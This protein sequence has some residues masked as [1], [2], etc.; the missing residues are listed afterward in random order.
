MKL[1]AV[2]DIKRKKCNSIIVSDSHVALLSLKNCK[3]KCNIYK[4]MIN[5]INELLNFLVSKGLHLISLWFPSHVGILGNEIADVLAEE[6]REKDEVDN[7]FGLSLD[8]ISNNLKN[9][10]N[11]RYYENVRMNV[12]GSS[13]I[14]YY[15][16]VT[17]NIPSV[18]KPIGVSKIVEL[19]YKRLRLGYRYPSIYRRECEPY[20]IECRP[21][22]EPKR[23]TLHQYTVKC[24]KSDKFRITNCNLVTQVRLC[25]KSMH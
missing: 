10:I 23:N 4:K 11:R 22:S 17:K 18:G 16:E 25:F 8:Q 21:C 7:D 5:R 24:N 9:I 20:Y 15:L 12:N 2:R 3:V 6:A 19:C 13:S 1:M 14:T